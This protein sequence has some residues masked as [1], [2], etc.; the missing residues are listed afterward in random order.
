MAQRGEPGRAA[1][2]ARERGAAGDEPAHRVAD[3]RDLLERDRPRGG[4]LLEQ[5]GEAPAMASATGSPLLKR[6]HSGVMPRSAQ[7]LAVAGPAL[8]RRPRARGLAQPV[9]E[10]RQPRGGVRHVR[11]ERGRLERDGPPVAAQGHTHR[12]RAA[13][14]L[15]PVPARAG[16]RAERARRAPSRPA[17]PPW[18]AGSARPPRRRRGRSR[19]PG[20]GSR[21]TR[22][23]RSRRGRRRPARRP[24]WPRVSGR[25]PL[26]DPRRGGGAGHGVAGQRSQ[27]PCLVRPDGA[28]LATAAGAPAARRGSCVAR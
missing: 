24:G 27:G 28:P 3:Q 13:L 11:R 6:S 21:R 16:Q 25:A 15:Q 17:A 23:G 22:A 8:R 20:R 9:H 1:A 7:P 5:R 2:A 10:D 26:M 19:R 12:E 14:A 4:R 18:R